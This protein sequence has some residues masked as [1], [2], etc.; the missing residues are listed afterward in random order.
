MTKEPDL[1]YASGDGFWTYHDQVISELPKE[2]AN[3]FLG[4]TLLVGIT[5]Y[6]HQQKEIEKKQFWGAITSIT[7]RKGIEITNPNTKTS[8]YLPPDLTAI[9]PAKKGEYRLRSTG[10]VIVDPDFLTTWDRT[11]PD[12]EEKDA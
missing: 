4:K 2:I 9:Y 11:A 3:R 8:F 5:Y 6:D 12:P 7:P 1:P 10:E